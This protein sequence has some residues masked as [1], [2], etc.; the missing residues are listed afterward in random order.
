M[1]GSSRAGCPMFRC[2]VTCDMR[3]YKDS[4]HCRPALYFFASFTAVLCHCTSV[5][6][7]ATEKLMVRLQQSNRFEFACRDQPVSL[8]QSPALQ[9]PVASIIALC[10]VILDGQNDAVCIRQQH[11]REL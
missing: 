7:T 5:A 9:G 1:E 8:Q 3:A 2:P 11:E 4:T 6:N 10:D